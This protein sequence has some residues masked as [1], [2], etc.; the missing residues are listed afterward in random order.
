[1]AAYLVLFLLFILY[2][3][4]IPVGISPFE[5]P[6]VLIAEILIEILLLIKIF[7]FKRSDLKHNLHPQLVFIAILFLVSL[8]NFLLFRP[9]SAFFGN[10]F[11]LQGLFLFWH[12]LLFS[13]ISK[14]IVIAH[15][16]KIFIPLSFV[17]LVMSTLILGVNENKRAFGTLGE[18][19]A[20]AASSVFLF[21]FIFFQ[22]NKYLK[23][24]VSLI[25]LVIILLSGS[26]AGLIAFIVE[27]FILLLPQIKLSLF[28]STLVG[29]A[30]LLLTL[31]L[32]ILTSN[33]S[34]FE[35]R[36]L[37]WQTSLEASK[38][39]PILGVGFG[40]IQDAIH[41]A[42][43]KLNNPVQYQVVDSAHNFL[44]DLLIQGGA[45]S[46][47]SVLLLIFLTLQ[48]F[49]LKKKVLETAVFLGLITTMLF[50]PVSVVH[51][52]A[53]WWLIGQGFLD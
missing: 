15:I 43:L 42:A 10:A 39:S 23:V 7:Q 25:T 20:L 6:K 48:R 27:L 13:I 24:A 16:K 32:P 47:I 19:N 1:M 40:N 9:E 53:F 31:T 8:V 46:L 22:S 5:A 11:R 26:R 21:P 34:W 38:N 52:V 36:G 35:N 45:V 28:K 41:Q 4:V 18:P 12:L 49:I 2:L 37:I 33:S 14:G 29:V 17:C 51:L 44:L 50:N 3:I 30:F